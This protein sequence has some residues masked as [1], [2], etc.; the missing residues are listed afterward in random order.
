MEYEKILEVVKKRVALITGEDEL[1]LLPET[2][3]FN[4]LNMD[5]NEQ[6]ELTAFLRKDFQSL[7]GEKAGILI[8]YQELRQIPQIEKIAMTIKGKIDGILQPAN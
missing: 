5:S 3:I 4:D 6:V 2:N 7:L 8:N 1:R